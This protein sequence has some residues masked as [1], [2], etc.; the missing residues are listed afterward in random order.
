VHATAVTASQTMPF[1][2]FYDT[3][4]ISASI[5]VMR[6]IKDI[7]RFVVTIFEN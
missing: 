3:S 1:S 2:A 6:M 5:G 4:L 7:Y